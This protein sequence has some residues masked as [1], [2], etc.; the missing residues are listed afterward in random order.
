MIHINLIIVLLIVLVSIAT[1]AQ[2]W[3][4][5]PLEDAY[6][7]SSI[8]DGNYGSN[9][10]LYIGYNYGWLNSLLQFDFT[11]YY[12]VE[13]ESAYLCLYVDY[14]YGTFPP[15]NLWTTRLT[16]NWNEDTVTFNNSP[17]T[18]DGISITGPSSMNA[19]WVVDI[20]TYVVG[21]LNGTNSNYGLMLG[22]SDSD[23]NDLFGIRSKEYS[24]S[25]YA[26][27][28]E[29]NYHYAT[30]QSTSLGSIKTLFE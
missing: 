21:W 16:D 30:I 20:T 15:N 23:N 13:V 9:D 7:D 25:T 10:H 27:K 12:G 26:P 17:G 29:L 22:K 8:P 2:V 18:T 5:P 24:D 11:G 3:L 28:L 19:W 4:Q 6:I 1:A 14:S